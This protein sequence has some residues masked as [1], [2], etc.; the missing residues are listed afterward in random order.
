MTN[1]WFLAY[2]FT[3][4]VLHLEKEQDLK[5]YMNEL[6]GDSDADDELDDGKKGKEETKA[7]WRWCWWHA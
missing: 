6:E 3:F 7:I 4:N 2:D 5:Q 1:W